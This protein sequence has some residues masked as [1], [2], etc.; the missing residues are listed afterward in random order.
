MENL[1]KT[2][3]TEIGGKE[4]I[5]EAADQ[6]ILD[7]PLQAEHDDLVPPINSRGSWSEV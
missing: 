1:G 2:F 7:K 3:K 5:V 4:V 6:V